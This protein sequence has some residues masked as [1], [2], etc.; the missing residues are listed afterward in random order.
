MEEMPRG[1]L[2]WAGWTLLVAFLVCV[3]L[4]CL[5]T[6]ALILVATLLGVIHAAMGYRPE[7]G[8]HPLEVLLG[9]VTTVGGLSVVGVQSYLALRSILGAFWRLLTASGA[10]RLPSSRASGSGR[11]DRPRA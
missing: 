5:F 2:R 8:V 7:G 4:F 9:V 3:F 11:A 6:L 10:V 1:L